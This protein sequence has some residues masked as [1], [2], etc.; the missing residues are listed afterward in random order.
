MIYF[1]DTNAF[2]HHLRGTDP[3]LSARLTQAVDDGALRL[4][5][6]VLLELRYGAEK[7]LL[8]REKR[9]AARVAQLERVVPVEVLPEEAAIHYGRLR[10]QLEK[11]GML[12]GAMDMLLAAHA[13]AVDA[14]VVTNNTRE[15]KRVAGLR[16]EDWRTQR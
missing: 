14:V 1:P 16:V 12:I 4:S 6:V 8:K 3:A 2:S 15:F 11:R 10:S 7:A 13:L 9:P 5:L